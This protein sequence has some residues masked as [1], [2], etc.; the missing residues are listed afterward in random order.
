MVMSPECSLYN[1]VVTT[2]REDVCHHL[3][4]V[5]AS[6]G[7]RGTYEV[8][9]VVVFIL[10]PPSLC[11]Y[12]LKGPPSSV[13]LRNHSVI[14]TFI[15]MTQLKCT[16]LVEVSSP[17]ILSSASGSERKKQLLLR[18]AWRPMDHSSTASTAVQERGCD[19]AH[20]PPNILTVAQAST[21]AALITPTTSSH[22]E[23]TR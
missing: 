16:V 7:E 15:T 20:L 19:G 22:E 14:Y 11:K 8:T 23:W 21:P 18:S 5:R 10:Q 12:K 9:R 1:F 17:L 3:P 4:C 6:G 2:Q 13:S